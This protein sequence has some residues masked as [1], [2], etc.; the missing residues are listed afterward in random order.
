MMADIPTSNSNSLPTDQSTFQAPASSQPQ[1]MQQ[2]N[3]QPPQSPNPAPQPKKKNSILKNN[4]LLFLIIAIAIII[5]IA[6]VYFA[7]IKSKSSSTNTTITTV[8]SSTTIPRTIVMNVTHCT[9]ISSPG[10]YY[11][12]QNI[13]TDAISSCIIINSNNVTLVGNKHVI[14]GEGPYIGL[15]PFTYGVEATNAKN[16]KIENLS[17]K[18][19]SYGIYFANITSSSISSSNT[20]NNEVS[21]IFLLQSKNNI[22]SKDYISAISGITSGGLRLDNSTSNLINNISVRNNAKYGVVINGTGNSFTNDIFT[23]NPIDVY[24]PTNEYSHSDNASN[25]KCST[26]QYCSFLQCDKSNIPPNIS[27]VILTSPISSCGTIS[28]PGNYY[29]D[30]NINIGNF[31]NLSNPLSSYPC[32]KIIAP[33]VNLNCN[34]HTISNARYGI[35]LSS[36]YQNVSNCVL[37]NDTYGIANYGNFDA[38]ITNV[39]MSRGLYGLYFSGTTSGLLTNISASGYTYGAYL[40]NSVGITFNRFN[41]NSNMYGAYIASN[42]SDNVFNGG[43]LLSNPLG[44][45]YCTAATYNY[46]TNL[47][48]NSQCG[49]TDCSWASSCKEITPP[50]INVHPID[51]CSVISYPGNYSLTS[52]LIGNGK[53]I[54]IKSNYVSLNCNGHYINGNSGSGIYVNNQSNITVTGCRITGMPTGLNI[55]DSSYVSLSNMTLS[56]NYNGVYAYNDKFANFNMINITSAKGI[57]GFTAKKLEDSYILN[58]SSDGGIYNTD[59]FYLSNFFNGTVTYDSA[60]GNSDYGFVFTNSTRNDI[61]NN[62]ALQNKQFDYYCSPDSSG[63]YAENG[64][65]NTGDTKGGCHWLAEQ[66]PVV[67]SIGCF[68][69]GKPSKVTLTTDMVYPYGNSCYNVFRTHSTSGNNTIINCQG[70]TVIATNGGTFTNIA[71]A[72]NVEITNCYLKN[73]T[74]A[75]KTQQQGQLIENNTIGGSDYAIYSNN[76]QFSTISKNNILNSTY[77]IYALNMLYSVISNNNISNSFVG[78]Y[79]N[80]GASDKILKNNVTYSNVGLELQNNTQSQFQNNIF[81]NSNEEGIAC[82]SVSGNTIISQSIDLGGNICNVNDGCLWM[83]SSGECKP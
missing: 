39:S 33:N 38:G 76:S 35:E 7:L 69:I 34:H 83:T 68:S 22:L 14:H 43:S 54:D 71:N 26:N 47:F 10:V 52:N 73:F 41:F 9:E 42:S 18:N 59:G 44:D 72:S 75:I 51:Q 46:T 49:V 29:I 64:G 8:L 48:Q 67:G 40:L 50:P 79:M 19:F 62:T 23:G 2:S 37:Y 21:G 53:C 61:Y 5:I 15:P 70:H 30:S 56:N 1:P 60:T 45:M 82:N 6:V 12:S 20:S 57:S 31:V 36:L 4:K 80:K 32:I 11:I 13:N 16:V 3:P 55:T 77:G 74:Y 66:N 28:K 27:A 25:V 63:L 78:I 24:C 58:S 17:V 81:N 65:I